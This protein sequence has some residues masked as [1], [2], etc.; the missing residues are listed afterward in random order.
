MGL[1]RCL[2]EYTPEE[3][4]KR[5]SE[6]LVDKHD[7]ALKVMPVLFQAAGYD[8][9]LLDPPYGYQMYEDVA[10]R[11]VFEDY[12]NVH[13]F[14]A[15]RGQ[16]F[17]PDDDFVRQYQ[18]IW[19]RNFFCFSLMKCSPLFFQP[20]LYQNGSYFNN[21]F[22]YREDER[23]SCSG[24]VNWNFANSFAVLES[25]PEIAGVTDEKK[26]TL[27]LVCN[28]STHEPTLLEEPSYTISP[29]VDNR[30]YDREH[31]DRF[32]ADGQTL[33]VES[34][35]QMQHYQID[36][37]ALLEL[38][39]WFD[40]LRAAGCYDNCRIILVSDHGAALNQV[41]SMIFGQDWGS[42]AMMYN[43]LLMVKD[44]DSHGFKVSDSLMTNADT[45]VL[46]MRGLITDPINPFTGNPISDREKNND[47]LHVFASDEVNI[48]GGHTIYPKD[49][50]Y[51]V[52]EDVRDG[53][54]WK[55]L[56]EW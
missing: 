43:P 17:S 25:M 33:H 11:P 13:T 3:M 42:D 53:D 20:Y 29:M 4:N 9:T 32:T 26:N 23:I 35:R 36:M 19:E 37:A 22:I 38:G 21:S 15:E 24:I 16:Y 54:N 56:G 46:A 2:D 48:S 55:L 47:E 14:E 27:L 40:D 49:R 12:Q 31:T 39:K 10:V 18:E 45:P 51:A 5:D 8:V 44:F 6:K 52:S 30:V 50:W 1:L 28:S 34:L 41:D 7:E